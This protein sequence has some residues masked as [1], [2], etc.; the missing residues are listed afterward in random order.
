MPA[1]P[2]ASHSVL[3]ARDRHPRANR[4]QTRATSHLKLAGLALVVVVLAAIAF[5]LLRTAGLPAPAPAA[6]S[7]LPVQ[8]TLTET[9]RSFI[10]GSEAWALVE[11]LGSK[12]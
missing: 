5:A 3:P 7:P 12:A 8:S 11:Q 6:T 1:T 9:T 2:L 10:G 4:G